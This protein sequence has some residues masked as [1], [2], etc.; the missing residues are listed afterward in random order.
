[1][2][3]ELKAKKTK[4]KQLDSA[5]LQPG[6]EAVG[7]PT[8]PLLP[9]SLDGLTG[10]S[11]D[12]FDHSK[13]VVTEKDPKRARISKSGNEL[14]T[15]VNQTG[16]FL[17]DV[18]LCICPNAGEKDEQLLHTGLFPSSFK[19]TETAFTF[20]VLDEYLRD[21]LECKTTAQQYY[22]KLQIITNRMFPHNVPV[23]DLPMSI[24]HDFMLLQNLYK[25]LLRASWQ[26]RDL[27]HRMES[28]LAYAQDTDHPIDGSMAIFCPACPQ[29]GINL[30]DDWQKCYNQ[31]DLSFHWKQ[32]CQ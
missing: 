25:Q 12:L 15:V 17:M 3:K 7:S 31:Y 30:S 11:D 2:A 20:S 8:P 24:C 22:S 9:L 26:W 32:R 14:L 18:L 23:C 28:G 4:T 10:I 6:D 13:F 16:V 19:Q 29:P 21:N 27:K 5:S 1:M